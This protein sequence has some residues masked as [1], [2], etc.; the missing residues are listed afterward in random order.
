MM[1]DERRTIT[2]ADAEAI[3]TIIEARFEE[4]FF[5]SMGH[6]AWGLVKKGIAAIALFLVA[7]GAGKGGLGQ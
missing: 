1:S 6:G 7:Y 4:K 2:D 3:A 5:S